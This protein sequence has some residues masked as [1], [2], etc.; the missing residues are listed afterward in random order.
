MSLAD[1]IGLVEAIINGGY[2]VTSDHHELEIVEEKEK[3]NI[4]LI[5]ERKKK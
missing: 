1:S 2:F 5:R 3:L 4:I